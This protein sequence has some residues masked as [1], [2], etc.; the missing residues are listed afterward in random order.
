MARFKD[1]NWTLPDAQSLSYEGSQV[2]VLMDIR[3]ELK[4]LNDLLHCHNFT[5]IPFALDQ[6]KLN[7]T[8]KKKKKKRTR[9]PRP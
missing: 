2:A 8:K 6:I 4:R 7:T 5:R 1:A 3:D 9:K